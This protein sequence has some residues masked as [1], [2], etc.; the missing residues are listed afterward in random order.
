MTDE[1]SDAKPSC[2]HLNWIVRD[3]DSVGLVHCPD[4]AASL[5]ISTALNISQRHYRTRMED[6]V[7]QQSITSE[8]LTDRVARLEKNILMV[9]D[10]CER[11]T[12]VIEDQNKK[13]GSLNERTMHMFIVGGK[14]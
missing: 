5:Y 1:N 6:M 7:I 8:H 9:L 4:C 2:A 3:S 11:L 12:E 13:L 14:Q 10:I